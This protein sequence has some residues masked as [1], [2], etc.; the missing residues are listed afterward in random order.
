MRWVFLG[1]GLLT[2]AIV[3]VM[4]PRGA[5]SPRRPLMLLP[6]LDFQ[7]RYDAQAPSPFFRD[8]RAMRTPPAGT[9]AFGGADYE[10]D[11]G[12][13]AQNPDFLGEDSRYYRGKDGDSWVTRIPI[14]VDLDLLRRGRERYDIYCAI[15]HGAT[16]SGK[17]LL[18]T[19]YGLAGVASISDELHALMPDG[20]F[21]DAI[22]SGKGRMMPYATQL[23]VRDRWAIVAYL[24]A[25]MRSQNASLND[26]PPERRAELSQ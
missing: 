12:S 6:D 3:S 24:R 5:I 8:G 9:V 21:F 7:P 1:I 11:A 10:S 4:G 23:K 19:Q 15:C 25:L 17:G 18:T 16:G 20:Q 14:K 13:P 22:T 2:A 26:V